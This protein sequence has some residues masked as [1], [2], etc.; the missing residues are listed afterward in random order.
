VHKPTGIR[1]FCQEERTQAANR[2][3]AFAILR[4]RLFEAELQRHQAEQRARRMSQ[5]GTGD[6]SEKI[7]TY[8][9]KD[10]RCSDHR[11]KMNFELNK[12]LDGEIEDNIQAMISLDQ[13]ERL[14][15]LADEMATTAA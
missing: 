9:Y 13:Q 5:V 3:R 2:E 12:A 6:R 15:E 4:A 10:G 7:K 8:N 11:L 1:I 14:R